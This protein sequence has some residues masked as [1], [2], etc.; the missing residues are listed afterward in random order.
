MK[1][2]IAVLSFGFM[3]LPG[4]ALAQHGIPPNPVLLPT[5]SPVSTTTLSGSGSSPQV[6]TG[7]YLSGKVTVQDGGELPLNVVIERVCGSN[8][9]ALGY[10]DKKGVFNVKVSGHSLASM[11]DASEDQRGALGKPP[12]AAR[13]QGGT[14]LLG[15]VLQAS[16]SGFRSGTI[17]IGSQRLLD[18][19]N[20]GTLILSRLGGASGGVVSETMLT[21]PKS[22]VKAY[23]RGME[24]LRKDDVPSAIKDFQKAV[25]L[26]PRFA[27]AWYELGHFYMDV[28]ASEAQIDLTKALNADPK[29]V[30]P[31]VD[32][33]I[34]AYR[35]RNWDGTIDISNRG[36]RLDANS[37]PQLYYFNAAAQFNKRNL[38]QAEK[39]ARDT[40]RVDVDHTLPKAQQ[41]LSYVL[42]AQGDFTGAVDQMRAYI[43]GGLEPEDAEKARKELAQL[44]VRA[45]SSARK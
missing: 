42:A 6:S 14:D 32:L 1:C 30:M 11:V 40:M 17:D 12:S 29:F 34:L 24:A 21:A 16:S 8:R 22:A 15:C 33:A 7:M 35:Q 4:S 25:D 19:P 9:R 23:D 36:I 5:T 20:V 41:L 31:Y 43:A 18:N 10:A 27:S 39:R 44:E 38:E 37:F 13:E 2:F 26:H 28:N 45:N 3:L